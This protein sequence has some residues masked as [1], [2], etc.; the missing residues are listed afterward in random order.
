LRIL[1]VDPGT[2]FVGYG[3]IEMQRDAYHPI[4]YG[5]VKVQSKASL[6]EKL[7]QIYQAIIDLIAETSCDAV[8]VED[9]FVSCNAKTSL[10]LGHARGVILLAAAQQNLPVFEYAPREIKQA[11]VGQGNAS[12]AQIQWM[13]GQLLRLK[14]IV[15]EEDTADGL[16]VAL[17]HG[18]KI[19]SVQT[20][21][22]Q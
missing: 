3:V 16:A 21:V 19:R 22:K 1:G 6:A 2:A 4:K 9:V 14:S 7:K 10:K 17:C 13:I 11:I 12:K 8:V 18:L 20:K 5:R 15:L